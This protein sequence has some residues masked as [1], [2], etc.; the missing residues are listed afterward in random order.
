V[1]S[2][3]VSDNKGGRLPSFGS[4]PGEERHIR[5]PPA[6][7]QGMRCVWGAESGF[8]R[9]LPDLLACIPSHVVTERLAVA[10]A[11]SALLASR[12]STASCTASSHVHETAASRGPWVVKYHGT[13]R[14]QTLSLVR[15]RHERGTDAPPR[16]ERTDRRGKSGGDGREYGV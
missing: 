8:V 1:G 9:G 2:S 12:R 16:R 15:S 3:S 6:Q 11:D 7:C 13:L 10:A 4:V 5:G 14:G